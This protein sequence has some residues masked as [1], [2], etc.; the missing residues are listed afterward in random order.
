MFTPLTK[1][2]EIDLL[3][4]RASWL[5]I[6]KRMYKFPQQVNGINLLQ[7]PARDAYVYGKNLFE[8]LFNKSILHSKI[9]SL[10]KANRQH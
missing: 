9:Y 7:I 3:A 1:Y 5:S 10:L 4:K 2:S 6:A 8:V